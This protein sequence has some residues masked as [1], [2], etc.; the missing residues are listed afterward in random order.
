VA[1]NGTARFPDKQGINRQ[2]GYGAPPLDTRFRKGQSG[3]PAGR[4]KRKTLGERI[5]DLLDRT[6]LDGR[7]LPDGMCVADLLALAIVEGAL[8]GKFSFAKE[9]LDRTEGKVPD[10]VA[11]PEVEPRMDL[12]ALSDEELDALGR[13]MAKLNPVGPPADM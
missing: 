9:V 2:V 4:P 10:R 8:E 5:A 3:N 1:T 13:I 12:S 7:A 6:E 11:G